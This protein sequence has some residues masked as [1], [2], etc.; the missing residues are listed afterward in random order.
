MRRSWV[1]QIGGADDI[2]R[3]RRA[4][5]IGL[6]FGEVGN[7]R[8]LTVQQIEQAIGSVH[9][10]P[11]APLRSALLRFTGD[12]H[13]G[14]LVITPNAGGHELW[15]SVIGGPY[16]YS[17]EPDVAQHHHTREAEWLGCLDR[18]TAWLQHKLQYI[19]TPAMVVELTGT[20]WWFEKLSSATLLA[21]RPPRPVAPPKAPRKPR[22]SA[23]AAPPPPPKPPEHLLC[24]GQCG[25]QW[26]TAV[27]I[28]GLCPDCR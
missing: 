17:A 14:D 10:G 12:M 8:D 5:R 25:L 2:D 19:D 27:L 4:G 1:V 24:A 18:S 22:A 15:F 3:L 23:P 16:E 13:P 11:A 21:E 9:S 20:E 28:D 7:V 6:R 26:R